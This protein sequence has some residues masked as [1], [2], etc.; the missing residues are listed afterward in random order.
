MLLQQ[1]PVLLSESVALALQQQPLLQQQQQQHQEKHQQPQPQ[2]QQQQPEAAQ[3]FDQCEQHETTASQEQLDHSHHHHHKHQHQQQ[4]QQQV[5]EDDGVEGFILVKSDSLLSLGG[6]LPLSRA[7]SL[8]R[9]ERQIKQIQQ[10]SLLLLLLLLLFPVAAAASSASLTAAAAAATAACAVFAFRGPLYAGSVRIPCRPAAAAAGESSSVGA[11]GGI[12]GVYREVDICQVLRLLLQRMARSPFASNAS[13]RE[14]LTGREATQLIQHTFNL[15]QNDAV[16]VGQQLL[17][18]EVWCEVPY[19]ERYSFEC[20]DTRKFLLQLR[21]FKNVINFSFTWAREA[22]GPLPL[23]QHLLKLTLD[24]YADYSVD[25]VTDLSSV[26]ADARCSDLFVQ[27]CELQKTDL[28]RLFTSNHKTT[29]FI[30]LFNLTYKL[31]VIQLGVP[32]G[33]LQRY[34]FQCAAGVCVDPRIHF[35]LNWGAGGCPPVRI[36]H[37]E[38]L[39]EE[40]CLATRAFLADDRNCRFG[41]DGKSLQLSQIFSWYQTDFGGQQRDVVVFL[42]PYLEPEKRD[43]LQRLLQETSSSRRSSSSS[44]SSTSSTSSSSLSD[45]LLGGF[46]RLFGSSKVSY[47]PFDWQPPFKPH[48]PFDPQE[49]FL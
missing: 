32:D 38:T 27:S 35:T 39:E 30:N 48:K 14:T 3:R 40:L 46:R 28:L 7:A 31:A 42:L 5:Q 4:Q 15:D 13:K 16:Y 26:R 29:F 34:R 1:P 41:E 6:G 17:D 11:A 45:L 10:R 24:L 23:V 33:L 19:A 44:T 36:Y 25:G 37:A 21:R 18:L 8:E 43:Q 22:A 9:R 12:V 20:T 2:Q 49:S 47:L